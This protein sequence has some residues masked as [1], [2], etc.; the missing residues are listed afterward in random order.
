MPQYLKDGA[1]SRLIYGYLNK[2]LTADAL[3]VRPDEGAGARLA[4]YIRPRLRKLF[5]A[6]GLKALQ[7]DLALGGDDATSS[8]TPPPLC[9]PQGH[10]LVPAKLQVMLLPTQFCTCDGCQV[11]VSREATVLDC[12]PCDFSL[13]DACIA[14]RSAQASTRVKVPRKWLG[15]FK[16]SGWN[17]RAEPSVTSKKLGTLT[18]GTI[19]TATESPKV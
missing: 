16:V 14:T 11:K 6:L 17:V 18:S 9:C 5:V 2:V 1:I 13:C 7:L 4:W 10:T 3:E 15:A 8:P 12:R 19:V